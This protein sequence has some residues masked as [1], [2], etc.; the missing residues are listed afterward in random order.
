MRNRVRLIPGDCRRAMRLMA[1]LGVQ[2]DSIVTDPPYHLTSIVK[3]FGNA[4]ADDVYK[5]AELRKT[6]NQGKSPH[7]RAATGFMGKQWD[8]GDIAFDPETWAL[9]MAVLKPGGHL[10]AFGGTRGWHRQA[11][12]IEDAGF[13]IRDT[14]AWL[15]GQ[16]FPKSHDVSKGID[17]AAGAEREVVGFDEVKAARFEKGLASQNAGWDRPWMHEDDAAQRKANITAPATPEAERWQGWGTA[18]KPAWESVVL[19][20][21]PFPLKHEQGIILSSLIRLEA[22][23]WLLSFVKAAVQNSTSSQSG[24]AEASAIAQWTADD[25]TNTRAGLSAGMDM[26]QFELATTISLSIVSSWRRTLEEALIPANTS[27]IETA[28]GTTIDWKTLNF[29]LS[30]ITADSII[31]ASSLTGGFHANASTAESHF[32]A[33]LSLLQHTLTLS[34]TGPALLQDAE[35]CRA[36]GV[37]PSFELIVLARKP[38]SEKTIAANVLRHGTGAVNVDG[39]RVATDE[40]T[41]RQSGVNGTIYGRDD[42]A[43]VRGGDEGR[44]PANVCHDGSEEVE[45]AFAAESERMGMHGAGHVRPHTPGGAYDGTTGIGFNGIG[46]GEKGFRIGDSG[47]AAR[48]FY[49]AKAGP[50]DRFGSKHPTV[51]PVALMRWLARLVTP[52]GGLIL[53]PFAGS[54][55][56]GIAAIAEGFRAVLIE[57]EPEYQADIRERLAWLAGE[58][59]HSASVKQRHR[60]P[61]KS[62]G[63]L[64]A[65]AA[66]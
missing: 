55:S 14:V 18:L 19:A 8:G 10:L 15:F 41:A 12:A 34:A 42:R 60:D 61:P 20:V 22:R 62:H 9:A 28:S 3:R 5:N 45:A 65:E 66:E 2:V 44:W 54:G 46:V 57:A 48:F 11:C 31:K 36:E 21:K 40:S 58:G 47:T 56:T 52:P 26:S 29:S 13:E 7:A 6:F 23:L 27:I 1:H 17:K 4:T 63:P 37:K 64:F 49:S 39:C 33:S 25:A 35:D 16:G 50:E 53:D 32:N 38:L 59:R 30:R 24:F 51:K 43:N